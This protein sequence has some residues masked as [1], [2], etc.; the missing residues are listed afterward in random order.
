LRLTASAAYDITGLAGGAD[1]RLILIHNIGSNNITL[2]DESASSA[3]AN[4]FALNG[5]MIISPD[6][7]A[8]LQYDTTAS[9]WRVL[10]QSSRRS[11]A[12]VVD[13]KAQNTS[14]GTFT[15]GA[16]RTRDLNT[17]VND[18]DGI[19]SVASNQM[20][21]GAGT[22]RIIAYA[23]GYN[24]NFHQTRL[25]NITDSSVVLLGSSEYADNTSISY[26]KSFVV[27]RFTLSA[28]KVLELQHIC[29]A[30]KPDNGFGVQANHASEI[31]AAVVLEK[32]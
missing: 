18:S 22:Y 5:D 3:A 31:Y 1:G 17:E 7:S 10:S 19:V 30:T 11:Y 15:S 8:V 20:T 9:R 32:E 12:C 28:S 6:M 24:V 16:W 13:Q 21:L 25:Y 2:K 23:P 26:G 29:S 27:G 14:G 4:R